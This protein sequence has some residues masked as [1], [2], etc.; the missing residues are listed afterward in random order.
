MQENKFKNFINKFRDT[1]KIRSYVEIRIIEV[2]WLNHNI[3]KFYQYLAKSN[4]PGIY[5]NELIKVLL[6]Q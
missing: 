4:R 5:D 6:Q 1:S 3:P 2:T